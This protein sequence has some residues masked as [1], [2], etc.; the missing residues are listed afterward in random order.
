[1]YVSIPSSHRKQ[2]VGLRI[3]PSRKM[4]FSHMAFLKK[5]GSFHESPAQAP[6]GNSR[7]KQSADG[8]LD[9]AQALGS[10][11]NHRG[12]RSNG[13]TNMHKTRKNRRTE[14]S[15]PN[16]GQAR[17]RV[18]SQRRNHKSSNA[19]YGANGA[20]LQHYEDQM[21]KLAETGETEE[22]LALSKRL[23]DEIAD[24]QGTHADSFQRVV[25][26]HVSVANALFKRE[27]KL[28]HPEWDLML[29]RLYDAEI[30]IRRIP[31]QMPSRKKNTTTAAPPPHAPPPP[32]P[33]IPLLNLF[34]TT[35]NN[36]SVA[37][38]RRGDNVASFHY[39]E[40]SS[41]LVA[42]MHLHGLK[43]NASNH[44]CA[45]L[46]MCTVLSLRGDHVKA[47]AHAKAAVDVA[48]ANEASEAESLAIGLFNMGVES[49]HL[50]RVDSHLLHA[51]RDIKSA[52]TPRRHSSHTYYGW[53][54]RVVDRVN[55]MDSQVAAQIRRAFTSSQQEM[56]SVA[57]NGFESGRIQ[58][59]AL[60]PV[61]R[62][63]V[64]QARNGHRQRP[65][66]ARPHRE[67]KVGASRSG[68][69]S[70]GRR[71]PGHAEDSGFRRNDHQRPRSA[72][73]RDLQSS[74][75]KDQEAMQAFLR[76]M[77]DDVVDALSELVP[78]GAEQQEL[79]YTGK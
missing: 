24:S 9:A 7:A 44:I 23:A 73:V 71:R 43:V 72:R 28:E 26:F 41:E 60:N 49:E 66:S 47:F 39:A 18:T 14:R 58:G 17:P 67:S 16:D 48:K 22:A 63:V 45:N 79:T 8:T 55:D 56:A 62:P 64:G 30:L 27:A 51:R 13:K 29:E 78:A 74:T 20:N 33:R 68:L 15:D 52:S 76:L 42:F 25:E 40:L 65:A 10:S 32:P 75:R 31:A 11:S 35:W 2:Q 36:L 77:S 6:K 5:Q 50:E 3:E 21:Y 53:A 59:R 37:L 57:T 19:A 46:V 1:V 69:A 54:A 38:R 34:V 61:D 4:S 70:V 12:N